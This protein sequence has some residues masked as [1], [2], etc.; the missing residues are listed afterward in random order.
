MRRPEPLH[1][2]AFLVDQDRRVGV[3]NQIPHFFNKSRN[4]SRCLDV[5]LE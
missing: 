4:L 5:A 2:T 3:T 1:P